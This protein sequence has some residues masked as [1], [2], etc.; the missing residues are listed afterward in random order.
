MTIAELNKSDT[1]Q[2]KAALSKCCGAKHWI[3]KMDTIFPVASEETLLLEAERIW[4]QC[5]EQD[6]LEA[7][8]HHPKIGDI[9]SLKKK[10][11]ATIAWAE[12][13]QSAVK[14]TSV[15]VLQALAEGNMTYENKF[16]YI[17]IVCATGKS[18][19]EMLDMLLLRLNNNAEKEIKIAMQEQN[20]ITILRLKKLLA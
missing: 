11:A 1:T 7:F 13:E 3:E 12:G 6:W 16:G 20:K 18:A 15:E 17:F 4:F 2:R 5:S 14:Q 9:N 10:Y 8:T 19:K